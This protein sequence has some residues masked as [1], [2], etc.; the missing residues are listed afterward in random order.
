MATFSSNISGASHAGRSSIV[1]DGVDAVARS[2]TLRAARVRPPTGS[3]V[4]QFASR[5]AERMRQDVPI[6]EG[7]LLDSITS[8]TS[9]TS[10]GLGV[11]A[12]AGPSRSANAGAFKAPMIEHGTVK[13][14]PQPFVGPSADRI[15]S[16][17]EQAMRALL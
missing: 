14:S 16:E 1:V 12:D 6:D 10:E 9:A 17:F 2:F 5:A 15:I 7:D 3:V 11:Y 13:M 4:V 8:D